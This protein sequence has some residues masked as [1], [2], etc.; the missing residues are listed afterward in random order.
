MAYSGPSTAAPKEISARARLGTV[1]GRLEGINNHLMNAADM[2]SGDGQNEAAQAT[3]PIAGDLHNIITHIEMV[4]NQ[5]DNR[6]EHLSAR[7]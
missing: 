4:I 7:L 2:I 3:P 6:L 1:A 5:I